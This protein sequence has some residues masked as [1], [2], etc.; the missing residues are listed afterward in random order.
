VVVAL[1]GLFL[2]LPNVFEGRSGMQIAL[3]LHAGLA[4]LYIGGSFI[5]M[6]MGTVGARGALDAITKGHVS[7]EWAEQHH[8]LWYY[9][10]R[11]NGEEFVSDED[12][13]GRKPTV[14]AGSGSTA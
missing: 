12:E 13:D 14:P 1:T 3:L 11:D 7:S 5:H 8:D 2:I 4:L 6:Y 9:E 10:V